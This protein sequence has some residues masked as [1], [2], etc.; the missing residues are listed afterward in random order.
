MIRRRL[1]QERRGTR[2]HRRASSLFCNLGAYLVQGAPSEFDTRE[3]SL[4][5]FDWTRVAVLDV[6]GVLSDSAICWFSRWFSNASGSYHWFRFRSHVGRSGIE[7]PQPL[8]MV[9]VAA[10][11]LLSWSGEAESDNVTQ[12]KGPWW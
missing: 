10:E 2:K 5:E 12:G 9:T 7:I 8:L 6:L 11:W 3:A 4:G 1:G